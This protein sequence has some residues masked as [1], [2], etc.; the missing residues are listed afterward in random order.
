VIRRRQTGIRETTGHHPDVAALHTN[1][2]MQWYVLYHRGHDTAGCSE[3]TCDKSGKK[4]EGENHRS[5]LPRGW[6]SRFTTLTFA[7][8]N[9][10]LQR[11]QD[12]V[13]DLLILCKPQTKEPSLSQSFTE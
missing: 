1:K 10:G 3:F 9:S 13:Q 12:V 11:P 4:Q 6:R 8:N 7:S 5:S 2:D